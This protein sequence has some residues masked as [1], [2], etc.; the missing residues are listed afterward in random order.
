MGPA[1]IYALHKWLFSYNYLIQVALT[2][3]CMGVHKRF[4]KQVIASAIYESHCGMN[5]VA[6]SYCP[7]S[8]WASL[9]IFIAICWA[10]L[11]CQHLFVGHHEPFKRICT[12]IILPTSNIL[13]SSTHRKYSTFFTNS[14]MLI[15]VIIE[16]LILCDKSNLWCCVEIVRLRQQFDHA[17]RSLSSWWSRVESIFMSLNLKITAHILLVIDLK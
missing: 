2:S 3:R 14:G 13:C 9:S 4:R 17:A 15:F 16:C 10:V 5:V 1:V 12:S 11:S 7:T 8:W 6:F